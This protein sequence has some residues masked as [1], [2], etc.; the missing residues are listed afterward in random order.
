MHCLVAAVQIII[1][2][3]RALG[4]RIG[5]GC[6]IGGGYSAEPDSFS[7]GDDCVLESYS[8]ASNH[9]SEHAQ[10]CSYVDP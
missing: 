5:S 2:F 4:T 8:A 7:I 10:L 3:Y 6:C 1:W 9:T